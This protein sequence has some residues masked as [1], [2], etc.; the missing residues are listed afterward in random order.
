MKFILNLG[1]L[2]NT[3]DRKTFA[4]LLSSGAI[5]K[6]NIPSLLPIVTPI[7]EEYKMG[8][9]ASDSFDSRMK[10]TLNAADQSDSNWLKNCWNAMVEVDEP[11]A[12]NLQEFLSS[13]AHTL[14]LVSNTNDWHFTKLGGRDFLCSLGITDENIFISH[15]MS[16]H[17]PTE[18][19][20]LKCKGEA[21]PGESLIYLT[22]PE[23]RTFALKSDQER[24][25]GDLAK[26]T[27]AGFV[28]CA[29]PEGQSLQEATAHLVVKPLGATSSGA[30]SFSF[31][32]SS[33]PLGD[34]FEWTL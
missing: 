1:N 13:G 14:Y 17:S 10:E 3:D 8:R 30:G 18:A 11:R 28:T 9:L 32:G 6:E 21:F 34:G 25:E 15:E 4:A 5:K 12:K 33:H 29:W 22:K 19:A 20:L 24:Y 31:F 23:A 26:L 16:S 2:V 7:I 27:E